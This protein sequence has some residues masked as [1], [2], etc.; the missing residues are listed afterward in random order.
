M[1]TQDELQDTNHKKEAK[2]VQKG[3]TF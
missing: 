1:G 3:H 2:K